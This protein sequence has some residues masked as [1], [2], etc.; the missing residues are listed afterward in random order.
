[1]TAETKL[2]AAMASLKQREAEERAEAK[3]RKAD[4]RLIY[5]LGA[6]VSGF[7]LLGLALNLSQSTGVE[8]GMLA[9]GVLLI[10]GSAYPV[11]SGLTKR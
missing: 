1:M 6:L 9:G 3:S 11:I 4:P 10:I 2:G 7:A 8:M 5:G